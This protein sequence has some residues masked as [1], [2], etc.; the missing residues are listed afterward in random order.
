MPLEWDEMAPDRPRKPRIQEVELLSPAWGRHALQLLGHRKFLK[1]LNHAGSSALN[2]SLG[3]P[4]RQ[5][6]GFPAVV[7]TQALG[8]PEG[9]SEE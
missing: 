4:G 8:T 7:Y 2:R 9:V 6:L 3:K 5:P 1:N